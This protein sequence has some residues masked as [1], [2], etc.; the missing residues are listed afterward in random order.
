M[1]SLTQ[2]PDFR[3]TTFVVIDFET[4]TPTGARPEP[5]DVAALWLHAPDG[6]LARTGRRFQ[7]LIRPR[8]TPRS[9]APTPTRPASP[10]R[11]SPGSQPRPRS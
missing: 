3:A 1:A 7:A 9:Q 5:I 11:W 6:I 4:T 2:D 8:S 10:Q